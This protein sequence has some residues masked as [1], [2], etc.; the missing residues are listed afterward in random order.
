VSAAAG[1]ISGQRRLWT[2]IDARM[3][4]ID[5]EVGA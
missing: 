5:I 2:R 4:R 3:E 1:K